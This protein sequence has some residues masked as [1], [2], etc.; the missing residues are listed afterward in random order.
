M[1]I[2]VR[3]HQE[4]LGHVGAAL[5]A[6]LGAAV[7]KVF[8]GNDAYKNVDPYRIPPAN[9]IEVNCDDNKAGYAKRGFETAGFQVP[10]ASG[11]AHDPGPND[12][13]TLTVTPSKEDTIKN[14]PL[15]IQEWGMIAAKAL[16]GA[17]VTQPIGPNA[18]PYVGDP[19][20]SMQVSCNRADIQRVQGGFGAAN[21][22]A[23]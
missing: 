19:G 10:T 4:P 5:A 18:D 14:Y 16:F 20:T 1:I 23:V 9:A 13:V 11:V 7:A 15:G 8:V 21:F 12:P 22:N 6:L 17:F 2:Q 3:S